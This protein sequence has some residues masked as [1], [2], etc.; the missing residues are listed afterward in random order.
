M[1]NLKFDYMTFFYKVFIAIL[2]VAQGY[3]LVFGVVNLFTLF[4]NFITIGYLLFRFYLLVKLSKRAKKLYMTL[5]EFLVKRNVKFELC[6]KCK[7]C[8]NKCPEC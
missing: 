7:G 5:P 6:D 4:V 8:E 2:I 1:T 3:A